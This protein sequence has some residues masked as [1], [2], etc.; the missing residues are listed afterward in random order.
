MNKILE[1]K[2]LYVNYG[3]FNVLENINVS[4]NSGEYIGVVGPNGSGKSTFVKSIA[5]LIDKRDGTIELRS[6]NI[7][8]MPQ[9]IDREDKLFPISAREVIQMGLNK[10][11]DKLVNNVAK[12]LGITEI[13][14]KRIG[15]LSGGQ[16]QKVLL[17]R[18]IINKPDLLILDEPTSAL[19][20][21]S[22]ENFYS[23]I[24]NVNVKNATTVILVSHDVHTIWK[25]VDKVLYIDKIV[26][27]FGSG[28]EY[29]DKYER[30][31]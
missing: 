31:N 19:D 25:Y 24:R 4:I 9:N 14:D 16:T 17:A 29:F 15:D 1:T 3:K 30:N 12:E 2:N 6:N 10:K 23:L 27:F 28:E 18:T 21:I 5:S 11:N 7:S 13:L 26:K 22:R 8:Y 20:K